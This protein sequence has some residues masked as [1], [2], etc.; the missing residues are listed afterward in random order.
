MAVLRK[1]EIREMGP[2]EREKQLS[3]LRKRLMKIKGGLASGGIPE[4][5]GKARE[6]KKTIAK[7]LTIQGGKK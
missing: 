1:Q 3:E 4:D 7:I 6:I 5:V 2:E